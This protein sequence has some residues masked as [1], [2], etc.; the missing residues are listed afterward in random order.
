MRARPG[1]GLG[2]REA[3]AAGG[4]KSERRAPSRLKAELVIRARKET[5]QVGQGPPPSVRGPCQ[6]TQQLTR[7]KTPKAHGGDSPRAAV[8]T[9]EAQSG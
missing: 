1:D 4:A 6:L 7:N 9:Q 3:H 2:V 5:A 8:S